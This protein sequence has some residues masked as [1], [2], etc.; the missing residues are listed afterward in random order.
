MDP[1]EALK[2]LRELLETRIPAS[3]MGKIQMILK[4]RE[5][6]NAL[7]GWISSGGFLP[8]DWN[9]NA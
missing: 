4:I 3:G 2:H 5:M 1:N 8:D 6:F 9:K 7:D